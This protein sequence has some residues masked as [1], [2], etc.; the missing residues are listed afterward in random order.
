M[1]T[2]NNDPHKARK[3]VLVTLSDCDRRSSRTY[4]LIRYPVLDDLLDGADAEDEYERRE[5][6]PAAGGGHIG[7]LLQQRDKQEETIGVPPELLEQEQRDERVDTADKD[8][9]TP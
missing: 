9:H 1:L 2:I 4:R 3:R 7:D 8:K 6:G 5:R